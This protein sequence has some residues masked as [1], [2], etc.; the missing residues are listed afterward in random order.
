MKVLT[1]SLI[2]FISF[3]LAFAN[4]SI[5]IQKLERQKRFI[6]TINQCSNPTKLDQFI[7]NALNNTS[8]YEKRAQHAAFIEELIKFNPSC[9]VASINKLD[10]KNC[11]KIDESYLREPF[12]YPREDLKAS[13]AT[14][15]N[16]NSS[17]LA[18]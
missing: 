3:S 1:A 9:F 6:S 17:C 10:H 4:Q 15:K 14:A 13:L 8:D 18:S 16:F 11:E 2:F 5:D 12:F 7:Q